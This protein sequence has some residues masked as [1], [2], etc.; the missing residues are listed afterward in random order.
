MLRTMFNVRRY[1]D[2]ILGVFFELGANAEAVDD[3][4]NTLLHSAAG[5]YNVEMVRQ[6]LQNGANALSKNNKGQTPLDLAFIHAESFVIENLAVISDL[7]IEAGAPV[8]DEMRVAVTRI[9]VEFE[10][11][12]DGYAQE[13]VAAADTALTKLYKIFKV[14][15]VPQRTVHDGVSPITAKPG[16]WKEQFTELTGLLIPSGGPAKTVQGEVIR[17]AGRIL[18]EI[19]RNGGVNWD[20][21]YRTMLDALIEH[22]SSGAALNTTLLNEAAIIANDVR[23]SGEPDNRLS[24]MCELAVMWVSANPRPVL[25]EK[26]NYKR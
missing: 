16:T 2:K 13:S 18:D 7:L 20:N 23:Q 6:L 4:G 14:P 3:E 17:I 8:T 9:G 1:F 11:H 5:E 10:F 22:F 25:L 12:R 26:P 24:R 19:E 15:P 21:D